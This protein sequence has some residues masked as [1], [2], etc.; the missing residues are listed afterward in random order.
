[1]HYLSNLRNRYREIKPVHKSRDPEETGDGSGCSAALRKRHPPHQLPAI[2][3][4][5]G[6][7]KHEYAAKIAP[8]PD[9]PLP[10]PVDAAI[11]LMFAGEDDAPILAYLEAEAKRCR[12]T[13]DQQALWILQAQLEGA[14]P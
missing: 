5:A 13:V 2:S 3:G 14:R 7:I 11:T 9:A 6:K 1:M 4:D 8:L 12:R 10:A